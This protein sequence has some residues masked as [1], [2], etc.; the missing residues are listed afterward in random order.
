MNTIPCKNNQIQKLETQNVAKITWNPKKNKRM[1][2]NTY[3]TIK[4]HNYRIWW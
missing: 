1:K 2:A 3:P 4:A